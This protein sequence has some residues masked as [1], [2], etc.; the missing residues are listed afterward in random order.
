MGIRHKMD[1]IDSQTSRVIAKALD[2]TS[3]RHQA[4]A[5][6]IANA[7]TAGY[8]NIHVAFEDSLKQAIESENNNGLPSPR[9]HPN[10]LKTTDNRHFNPRP[11]A[12]SVSTSNTLIEQSEFIYRYDK[13]GVDI[14]KQMA[15]LARNTQRYMAL[16]RME[17]KS[18]NSLRNIIKGGGM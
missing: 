6:N 3:K 7:E 12:S 8:K 1:L 18:F 16:S 14:E 2:G 13:N 11:L 17:S 15:D 5:S 9:L 4:I 10:S